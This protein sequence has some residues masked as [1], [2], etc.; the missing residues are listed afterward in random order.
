MA[1]TT[2]KT[3]AHEMHSALPQLFGTKMI[4]NAESM[5][6]A[7]VELLSDMEETLVGTLRAQQQALQKVLDL[8]GE[9]R[10]GNT[11]ADQIK[12]QLAVSEHCFN[13]GM[14]LWRDTAAR[15]SERTLK[16]IEAGRRMAGDVANAA[17]DTRQ[18][19]WGVVEKTAQQTKSSRRS[20]EAA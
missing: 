1:E 12:L 18:A 11:L 13:S 5:L 20:A 2:H 8:I 19:G 3:D 9:S 6:H 4:D 7:Q 10:G 15:M 16:R 14:A 17:D